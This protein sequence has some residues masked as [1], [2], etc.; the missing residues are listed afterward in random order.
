[1]SVFSFPSRVYSGAVAAN[2]FLG[3]EE[4]RKCICSGHISFS[5]TP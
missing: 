2:T 5:F 1:M 4:P 3:V